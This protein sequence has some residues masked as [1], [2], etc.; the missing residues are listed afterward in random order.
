MISK[1]K[2]QAIMAEYARTEGH[3]FTGSTGSCTDSKNPG[4]DRASENTPQRSSFQKRSAE[5]GRSEK[6]FAGLS[7]ENRYRKISCTD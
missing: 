6:R 5:N 7:E 1:E 3:R 4:A 2:K